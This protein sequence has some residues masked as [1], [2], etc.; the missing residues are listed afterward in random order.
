MT[1]LCG[2]LI[3]NVLESRVL[4]WEDLLDLLTLWQDN[5]TTVAEN[6]GVALDLVKSASEASQIVSGCFMIM[7]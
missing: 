5:D 7:F 3:R 1:L 2:R 4:S 6:F